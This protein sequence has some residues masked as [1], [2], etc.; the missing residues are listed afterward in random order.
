[1]DEQERWI[2]RVPL[3]RADGIVVDEDGDGLQGVDGPDPDG[4][5]GRAAA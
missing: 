4:G 5:R 2:L 3:E 1:M